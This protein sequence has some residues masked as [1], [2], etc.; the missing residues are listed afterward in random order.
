MNWKLIAA[1]I[2]IVAALIFGTMSFVESNIEYANF[3]KAEETGKKV[4][5]NGT[6]VK[7]QPSSFDPD[8]IQFS[9]YMKDDNDRICKVV[10][11]GARPNNFEQATSVVVKGKYL[12]DH[13]H[14]TE[15][16]TKCPSK[17]EGD[18]SSVQSTL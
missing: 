1:V 17:Y 11:D 7:E 3:A 16:L 18:S 5:V 6:W 2:V 10:L 12:D 13:F 15:I 4:Q 9:F 14:A 8:K